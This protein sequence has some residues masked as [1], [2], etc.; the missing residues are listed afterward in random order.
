MENEL[1][2]AQT[3]Q[4]TLFPESFMATS[5]YTI[6]GFFEPASECGGDWWYFTQ[7]KDELLI[8]IGDAT[9]HGAPAALI[10]SAARASLSVLESFQASPK[11]LVT[12]MNR[13]IFDVGRGKIMMTFFL[14]SYHVPSK[15]LTFVNASHEAPYLLKKKEGVLKKKDLIPLNDVN[16]PRLGQARDSS[17]EEATLQLESGDRIFAYTDGLFDIKNP[18]GAAFGEREFLKLFL[19]LNEDFPEVKSVSS[20]LVDRLNQYRQHEP[21]IDDVTYWFFDVV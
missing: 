6:Q 12:L 17:F 14:A 5:A 9:G 19:T 10:T 13:A 4:E 11:E 16:S 2:T 8:L 3:V 18:Q 20:L 7:R 1:K 21:L 15:K